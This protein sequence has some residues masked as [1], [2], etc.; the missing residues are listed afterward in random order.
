MLASRIPHGKNS[1][2]DAACAVLT[3]KSEW[4]IETWDYIAPQ[5]VAVRE[6]LNIEVD[7][8]F[9]IIEAPDKLNS[10]GDICVDE[11]LIG[12]KTLVLG[13]GVSGVR[14]GVVHKTC[15]PGH[16]HTTAGRHIH[17]AKRRND[18][19]VRCRAL[20]STRIIDGLLLEMSC[21]NGRICRVEDELSKSEE[22][23][24]ARR[25]ALFTLALCKGYQWTASAERLRLED[26]VLPETVNGGQWC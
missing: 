25:G 9:S 20:I 14:R 19:C 21:E 26:N 16:V 10:L 1:A 6:V 23:S 2:R 11:D 5:V 4:R 15:R 18:H 8:A 3:Q 22:T 7:W 17:I 24:H 13:S 12:R